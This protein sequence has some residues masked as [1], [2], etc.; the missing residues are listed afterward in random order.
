MT[1]RQLSVVYIF[2]VFINAVNMVFHWSDN[3]CIIKYDF[4]KNNKIS[5]INVFHSKYTNVGCHSSNKIL[6]ENVDVT[7]SA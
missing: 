7:Q 2:G 4:N 6:E 3:I 1:R 5:E